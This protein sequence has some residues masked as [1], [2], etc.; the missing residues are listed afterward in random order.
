MRALPP[1]RA[2]AI[3]LTRS[4]DG[5]EDLV[6]DTVL[7]AITRQERFEPGTNM[8]AWLFTILR[9]AYFSAHR[10]TQ[11]EVEDGAGLYSSTLITIAD[12]EHKIIMRNLEAALAKLSPEHR[13]ALILVG[14]EG[15]AYEEAATVL[16]VKVGT[17][18]S[19]VNRARTRLAE[20]MGMTV[21]D[22]G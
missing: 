16:G 10:K 12:Q 14:A 20:L 22:V 18:K 5:A 8:E 11:R 3:N 6:R 2:F 9:N 17:M 13:D 4:I 19:R 7:K 21:T 15:M 1:L